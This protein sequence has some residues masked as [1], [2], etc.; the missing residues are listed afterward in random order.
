VLR[1]E[2]INLYKK[3]IILLE[4]ARASVSFNKFETVQRR[5]GRGHTGWGKGM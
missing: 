1:K 3:N 2:F 5:R 4:I